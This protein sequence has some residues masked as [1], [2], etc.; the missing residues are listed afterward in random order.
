V[1]NLLTLH[2]NFF[3]LMLKNKAIATDALRAHLPKKQLDNF[4]WNTLTFKKLDAHNVAK[5]K[6]STTVV[7]SIEY[8][9][10]PLYILF[11]FEPFWGTPEAAFARIIPYRT[12]LWANELN[13]YLKTTG[14]PPVVTILYACFNVPMEKNKYV[15]RNKTFDQ[16]ADIPVAYW[17]GP[18]FVIDVPQILDHCLQTHGRMAGIDLLLKYSIV[19]PSLESLNK[20]LDALST[21]GPYPLQVYALK[22]LFQ[23][24]NMDREQMATQCAQYFD[25]KTIE[26]VMLAPC[27]N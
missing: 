18:I 16:D 11:H 6:I 26:S 25:Q 8:E 3:S 9:K 17:P 20:T 21:M 1:E 24:W 13:A 27:V 19:Q 10:S 5:N 12:K 15:D 23:R 14:L 4:D 22:F 2:E 7:F